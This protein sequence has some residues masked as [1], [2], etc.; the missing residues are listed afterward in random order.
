MIYTRQ[1]HH[2]ALVIHIDLNAVILLI[3]HLLFFEDSFKIAYEPKRLE[4]LLI[5]I[6][7]FCNSISVTHFVYYDY[8]SVKP[9]IPKNID[10]IIIHLQVRY[11]S[12]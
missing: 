1:W 5:V 8:Y 7:M 6:F 2:S 11:E 4:F 10:S 3:Y 12:C 9:P